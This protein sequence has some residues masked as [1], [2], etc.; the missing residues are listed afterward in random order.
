[1]SPKYRQPGYM[2]YEKD[3]RG[4]GRREPSLPRQPSVG[5]RW[6]NAQDGP[7][8]PQM[9]GTRTVARCYNCGAVLPALSKEM[10]QCGKCQADLRCCKM[11]DHFDPG[12]RFECTETIEVR[13][14]PKDRRTDCE[15]FGLKTTVE[16]DTSGLGDTPP[17]AMPSSNSPGDAR[18]AFEN[19][20]KK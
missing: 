18:K 3:D 15:H 17:Q 9:A 12:S 14:S 5:P 1:M 13:V 7:H 6:R 11:C 20:F 16:K 19:L 2:D 4:S 8:S 10:G